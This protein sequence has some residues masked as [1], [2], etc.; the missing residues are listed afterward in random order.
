MRP[1]QAT[2]TRASL[3][4]GLCVLASLLMAGCQAMS[5]PFA[6]FEDRTVDP[7]FPLPETGRVAILIEDV[8]GHAGGREL[9]RQAM[10]TARFALE[11]E[12]EVEPD[13]LVPIRDLDRLRRDVGPDAFREMDAASIGRAVDA[14]WVI[15][16]TLQNFDLGHP[17]GTNR[18]A[19][20]LLTRLYD[21]A[22]DRRAFP[23]LDGHSSGA[24]YTGHPVN[25]LL[26]SDWMTTGNDDTIRQRQR[27][28]ALADEAGWAVARVF[29]PW[30]RPAPGDTVSRRYEEV[31]RDRLN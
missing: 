4:L 20:G 10:T 13:R 27:A 22:A 18:A 1:R 14:D 19:A 24:R 2:R 30:E 15:T 11:R 21:V 23:M 6:A 26:T 5:I 17:V 9:A 7:A 29:Y 8:S 25:V 16:A 28:R 31:K 12:G 3:P